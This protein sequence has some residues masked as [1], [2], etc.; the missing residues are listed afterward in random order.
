MSLTNDQVKSGIKRICE[1]KCHSLMDIINSDTDKYSKLF[2]INDTVTQVI[3]GV[4][5]VR[6]MGGSDYWVENMTLCLSNI[7]QK[8]RLIKGSTA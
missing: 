7:I 1:N 4:E 5:A 8:E 2:A 3:K 6:G